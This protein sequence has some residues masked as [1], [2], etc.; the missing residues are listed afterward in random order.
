MPATSW[1]LFLFFLV[2][3]ASL[4]AAKMVRDSSAVTAF[5]PKACL[6]KRKKPFVSRRIKE[7]A[8]ISRLDND[9][10]QELAISYDLS[11]NQSLSLGIYSRRGFDPNRPQKVNQDAFFHASFYSKIDTRFTCVGVLDGHGLKGHIVSR[12]LA[13]QLPL[14][15]QQQLEIHLGEKYHIIQ[16]DDALSGAV[17]TEAAKEEFDKLEQQLVQL[18]GLS[19]EELLPSDTSNL[20][21]V[22]IKTFHAAHLAALC[23]KSIPAGRN[24]ATCTLILLDHLRGELYTANVGDS[25]AIKVAFHDEKGTNKEDT[26]P[27][28][29]TPITTETTVELEDER[30]RID[31]K[32]GYI[33]GK[34][35]FYGPVGIAM[36]RVLG[37]AVML[38]A[39]VV[40]TPIVETFRLQSLQEYMILAT[41]GI[42]DVMSDDDVSGIMLESHSNSVHSTCSAI[43]L[44]A[45][46]KWVGDLPFAD[47]EYID[48]ITCMVVTL[49]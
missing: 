2:D 4:T 45:R 9:H 44:E 26:K 1:P 34:N 48:D 18:G 49:N 35:V 3:I 21:S 36:T 32:E 14:H 46:R 15:L 20:R 7:N 23:D 19:Q 39:G 11:R 28:K 22:L 25:R 10:Q 38:R 16:Q 24:G 33:A 37:D 17:F 29:V 27:Y 13:Q 30:G 6:R 31:Q 8:R 40:P 47:E 5:L 42:W 43:A 12:F 41:D